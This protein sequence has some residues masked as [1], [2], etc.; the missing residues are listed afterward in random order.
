MT[1]TDLGQLPAARLAR[2][3]L[4]VAA[5]LMLVACQTATHSP[6]LSSS[7]TL[8][9]AAGSQSDAAPMDSS[10]YGDYLSGLVATHERDLSAAADFM[11]RALDNDPGN[12][13]LLRRAFVLAAADGRHGETLRLARRLIERE[14]D[15]GTANAALA[16]DAVVRND[17]ERA[18]AHLEAMADRGLQSLY[19]PLL[20]AW[21]H[22]AD[23]DMDAALAAAE[24]LANREGFKSL[25]ALHEAL[26]Y[27]V[28]GDQLAAEAA[29]RRLV[30]RDEPPSFRI[31]WLG[32]NFFE[33]QGDREMAG[34]VYRRY[35]EANPDSSLL[36]AAEAR[37]ANDGAASPVLADYRQGWAEVFF[38]IAG[39]LSQERADEMALIHAHFALRLKP[40]LEIAHLLIGEILESQDRGEAAIAVYRRIDPASPLSWTA[41]LRIAE[42]LGRLERTEEAVAELETLATERP[43]NFEPLYRMGNLLRIQERFGEAAVAYDRAFERVGQSEQHHWSLFYFRGIALE[44]DKQWERAE[45]DFLTALELEPEQPYVMNYLAYSW[46]E[47][48]QHFDEAQEMLVRAVEL[49]PN[50][51]YIVDSLGWVYFRLGAY[52]K[53][54]DQ[55]ERAVELRPQDP[56]IND[57]LGDAYWRVGRQQEAR[58]QW[59]RALSFEPE[60]DEVPTIEAKIER[61]LTAKP[62]NI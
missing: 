54:V 5:G 8:L 46:I 39:V 52:D 33:R 10:P 30:E 38:D 62:E 57:H 26:L 25:Y 29:Y 36:D 31:A 51:G 23:G 48:K 20:K 35:H 15:N 43:D 47:Q 4:P 13:D 18:R 60:V 22:I 44:R 53:A 27:D 16:I 32:G 1:R 17:V 50:D 40:D 42:E 37:L 7:N 55:L 6:Q 2:L 41:R 14:A 19:G 49:R 11:A 58:F 45:K 61:G 24:P 34:D 21:L 9:A 28:G 12:L 3:L 56:V 59:R